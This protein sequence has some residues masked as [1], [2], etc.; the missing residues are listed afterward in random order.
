[1]PLYF[2]QMNLSS[3]QVTEFV[4]VFQTN[5]SLLYQSQDL[6]LYF[7][8]KTVRYIKKINKLKINLLKNPFQLVYPPCI[9]TFN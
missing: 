1:M 7:I 3:V 8:Y 2:K 4:L 5:K 9:A 6:T